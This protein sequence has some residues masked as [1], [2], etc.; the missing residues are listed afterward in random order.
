MTSAKTPTRDFKPAL[1][2]DF[3]TGL[4]D[5]VV[6]VSTRE[7]T[8]KRLAIERA[9]LQPGERVL[10]LGCGT[11][12]LALM[13]HAA[14]PSA[15][16]AGL[17]ADPAILERA[18]AKTADAG[19]PIA[20]HEGFSNQLPFGDGEFDAVVSTLFFHHLSDADKRATAAEALRVL[21]PAGRVVVADLG[22]PQDPAMRVV[23]AATVQLLDGRPTTSLNV[24]GGLPG[25]FSDA[26]FERVAVTDRLRTPIGTIELLTA[27]RPPR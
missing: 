5:P 19:A 25:V 9:R 14:Q 2:F 24:A 16:I 27:H 10:D 13:A 26:G 4:F 23:A 20:F 7:R 11:G 18:R 22:R 6:A 12:T 17:D 8:F 1:R 3:L 15:E 21:A